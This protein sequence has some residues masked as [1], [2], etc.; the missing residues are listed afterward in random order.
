MFVLSLF[1][2]FCCL[3]FLCLC[4]A[5]SLNMRHRSG[6]LVASCPVVCAW[7]FVLAWTNVQG[8]WCFLS[9]S[10]V[11]ASRCW[12]WP[13]CWC[14]Y[15]VLV[16]SLMIS[17]DMCQCWLGIGGHLWIWHGVLGYRVFWYPLCALFVRV[18]LV[19]FRCARGRLCFVAPIVLCIVWCIF[20]WVWRS[21]GWRLMCC[22]RGLCRIAVVWAILSIFSP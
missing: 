11:P 14:W 12:V 7:L 1:V 5:A 16:C 3:C 20:Q 10:S 9:L 22:I 4:Y 13:L 6:C 18:W 15:T 21:T 2:W 19:P 17:Q 8:V